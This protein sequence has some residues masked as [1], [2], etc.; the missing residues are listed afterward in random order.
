MAADAAEFLLLRF[1][2][3]AADS[4]AAIDGDQARPLEKLMAMVGAY[5]RRQIDRELSYF[6]LPGAVALVQ[7]GKRHTYCVRRCVEQA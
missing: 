2:T 6:E 1:P 5:S 7:Q 4:T 3:V